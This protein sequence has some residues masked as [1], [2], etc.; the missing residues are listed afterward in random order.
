MID[1]RVLTPD[2][3]QAIMYVIVTVLFA[4]IIVLKLL[5]IK[6]DKKLESLKNRHYVFDPCPL[7]GNIPEVKNGYYL[8]KKCRLTMY[9]PLRNY[10]SVEEMIDMTWNK[11]WKG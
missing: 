5:T 1:N 3:W 6:I 2:E 9:I 4:L 7:C 11:R 8:C 10:K